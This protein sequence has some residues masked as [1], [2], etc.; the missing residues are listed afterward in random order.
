L[1]SRCA[2]ISSEI[3]TVHLAVTDRAGPHPPRPMPNSRFAHGLATVM[4]EEPRDRRVSHDVLHQMAAI[5]SAY[6]GDLSRVP[7]RHEYHAS[8]EKTYSAEMTAKLRLLLVANIRDRPRPRL[9]RRAQRSRH[10][11]TRLDRT[12]LPRALPA[13]CTPTALPAPSNPQRATG[14]A[15]P[16]IRHRRD[17]SHPLRLHF[18]CHV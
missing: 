11:L 6:Q 1:Q 14:E 17:A 3:R 9:P 15:G 7:S 16:P 12:G 4:G 10:R 2:W 13:T 8:I 18:L 5:N